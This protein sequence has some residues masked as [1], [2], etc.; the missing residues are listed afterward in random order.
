[1][2]AVEASALKNESGVSLFSFL[3]RADD[4]IKVRPVAS[5]EFGVEKLSISVNFER[6]AARRNQFQ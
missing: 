5:L 6:P 1:M 2:F 3:N 4:L